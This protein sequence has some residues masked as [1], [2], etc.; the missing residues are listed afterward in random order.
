MR[1]MDKQKLILTNGPRLTKCIFNTRNIK[2]PIKKKP[3]VKCKYTVAVSKDDDN[4]TID[5]IASIKS[6][7]GNIP[8]KFDISLQAEFSLH[9]NV[10]IDNEDI[11]QQSLPYFY[12][13]MKDLIIELTSKAYIK[14]FYLPMP[15]S[16]PS[17]ENTD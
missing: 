14:P 6:S 8:F 11:L 4:D 10:E 1:T 5:I 16:V 7:S 12:T 17:E 3:L 2:P 13:T 15:Y 9:D